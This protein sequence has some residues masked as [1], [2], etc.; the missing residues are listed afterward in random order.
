MQAGPKG[1]ALRVAR[2]GSA[3]FARGRAL[4]RGTARLTTGLRLGTA[5]VFL[6]AHPLGSGLEAI[7]HALRLGLGCFLVTASGLGSAGIVFTPDQLDLGHFRGIPSANPKTQDACIAAGP[8]GEARD[9]R[10]KQLPDDDLVREL[11]EN[12]PSG[13]QGPSIRIARCHTALRNR[14]E[15]LDEGSKL[16]CLRHRRLDS[17]MAKQ[18]NRLI[19]QERD[20]MLRHATEF[21]MGNVVS[22]R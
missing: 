4:S 6:A 12:E 2:L 14:N 18:G 5:G 13:A 8:L 22:H 19:A 15:T 1:P 3:R 9:N 20:S 7:A 10:V 21:S 16:L 17:L 11:R